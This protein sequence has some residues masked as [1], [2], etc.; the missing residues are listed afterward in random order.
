MNWSLIAHRLLGTVLCAICVLPILAQNENYSMQIELTDDTKKNIPVSEIKSWSFVMDADEQTDEPENQPTLS[1]MLDNAMKEMNVL[2]GKSILFIG[3]SYVANN[4]HPV[5]ETWHY[6]MAAKNHMTY[7]NYGVNGRCLVYNDGDKSSCYERLDTITINPDYIITIAG[8]NDY[9][10]Q[11]E[12]Q[13]FKEALCLYC[14]KLY[15]KFPGKKLAF[16]TPWGISTPTTNKD[17]N[18]IKQQE[19]IDAIVEVAG[20]Y[21]IPVFDAGRQSGLPFWKQ[22]FRRDYTQGTYSWGDYWDYSHLNAAGHKLFL[23]KGESFI[24]SL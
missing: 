10:R 14:E 5:S 16:F 11:M 23:N 18:T 20:M 7:Y 9:G 1:E 17:G 12:I 8:R 22:S 24:R 4:G 3:D 2:Y 19:Y 15:D 21:A 13:S 6:M